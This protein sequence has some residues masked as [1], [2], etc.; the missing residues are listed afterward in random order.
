MSKRKAEKKGIG[1]K[2]TWR[3]ILPT[4]DELSTAQLFC[5]Y[6]LLLIAE[7]KIN[8]LFQE[9]VSSVSLESGDEIEHS[10]SS[11]DTI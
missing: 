10:T 5:S 4:T 11:K 3:A 9:G 6:S 8:Q 2:N 1:I 7:K